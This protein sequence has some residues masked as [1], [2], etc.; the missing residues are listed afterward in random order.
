MLALSP[1][2]QSTE[3]VVK[4]DFEDNKTHA[5]SDTEEVLL[6]ITSSDM[7]SVVNS[8]GTLT[9]DAL[10]ARFKSYDTRATGRVNGIKLGEK[11]GIELKAATSYS[12][13]FE[14]R[15]DEIIRPDSSDNSGCS[16]SCRM[17]LMYIYKN[18]K[19]PT[20]VNFD[21]YKTDGSLEA[22]KGW[23][24]PWNLK[25][26]N[27]YSFT[28]EFTTDATVADNAYW[29]APMSYGGM[30]SSYRNLKLASADGVTELD[31]GNMANIS[32]SADLN[33]PTYNDQ[34]K[35]TAVSFPEIKLTQSGTVPL[36][37]NNGSITL[38]ALGARF[39]SYDTNATGRVNGIKIG[40]KQGLSLNPSTTYQIKF[41]YRLDEIIRPD[42][43][44]SKG[45]SYSC[46]SP[47]FY[48]YR[49]GQNPTTVTFDRYKADGSLEATKGWQNPWN[50]TVG[51]WYDFTLEFTTAS[52]IANNATYLAPISYGGMKSTYRNL[53]IFTNGEMVAAVDLGA[54]SD[55]PEFADISTPTYNDTNKNTVKSFPEIAISQAIGTPTG[56]TD[57]DHCL[58]ID[59]KKHKNSNTTPIVNIDTDYSV[60]KNTEYTV[61]FDYY[62]KSDSKEGNAFGLMA[63]GEADSNTK[64]FENSL[65]GEWRHFEAEYS[66]VQIGEIA[67]PNRFFSLI[68]ASTEIQIYID[69]FVITEHT[70]FDETAIPAVQIIDFEADDFTAVGEYERIT[71]DKLPDNSYS[72]GSQG[73]LLCDNA[74]NSGY[75]YY[76]FDNLTFKSNTTYEIS[77]DYYVPQPY[78]NEWTLGFG[79]NATYLGT[80]NGLQFVKFSH[81]ETTT[82][83]KT[84]KYTVTTGE[85]LHNYAAVSLA[86]YPGKTVY[87]DNVT[88]TQLCQITAESASL[89]QGE[90][91]G[92]G[93][94]KVGEKVTVKAIPLNGCDFDGWYE[95]GEKLANVGN[96]YTF[97]ASVDRNLEA[98]FTGR[99]IKPSYFVQDFEDLET[100][101]LMENIFEICED[102]NN[103]R[104]GKKSLH[105]LSTKMESGSSD[106]FVP[107]L[108]NLRNK[109]KGDTEYDIYMWVKLIT[110]NESPTFFSI[111]E[112]LENPSVPNTY[113]YNILKAVHT[114]T[115]T[116]GDGTTDGEWFRIHIG[117]LLL[118]DINS[119]TIMF[120]MGKFTPLTATNPSI[121]ELYVDDIEIVEN[122]VNFEKKK[123]CYS[124]VDM[125]ENGDFESGDEFWADLLPGMTVAPVGK[126][127]EEWQQ[128]NKLV[129]KDL[130]GAAYEKSISVKENALYTV[131]F[132]ARAEKSADFRLQ[133]TSNLG[134]DGL[135]SQFGDGS[136]AIVSLTDKWKRYSITVETIEG[137]NSL[138]LQLSNSGGT[139]EID[140]LN[141]YIAG[142]G[143]EA[144]PNTYVERLLRVSTVYGDG[145]T[146]G[147]YITEDALLPQTGQASTPYFIAASV[148]MA[149]VAMLGCL[150]FKR[151]NNLR[152]KEK[153]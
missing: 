152:L 69:N 148:F 9:L 88:A 134:K 74:G 42:S 128:R 51:K 126:G 95:N 139:V 83:W 122:V 141:M 45:C 47:L 25:V 48:I 113:T 90:T 31:F 106:R 61:E 140:N 54:M 78:Y 65:S 149:S 86:V 32:D 110:N 15:I 143:V 66:V 20:T 56:G 138:I 96:V 23:Q 50:M 125:F 27:W 94:Y 111:V 22:T 29:L 107:L 2:V 3:T 99:S 77:V 131:A 109:L 115:A 92:G 117:T 19:D 84:A 153:E 21:R 147:D 18:G 136:N 44:E 11:Q 28:L 124:I 112:Q 62:L 43:T 59:A 34:N 91:T 132:Y 102:S 30:K 135:I 79:Y 108:S 39:K 116:S 121:D 80:G 145:V 52:T 57:G 58:L 40:A 89:K 12:V 49:D 68:I 55:I 70:L 98:R 120:H 81:T 129:I 33:T 137:V 93:G 146:D 104:S 8:G 150:V 119:D 101:A 24:N 36:Q 118:T 114:P 97:T 16:Y 26:G 37:K 4:Y 67:N 85:V 64:W 75:Q 130:A 87:F 144:D 82:G 151:T 73:Y 123:Y 72:N 41:E 100:K 10:G 60:K 14:F 63:D 35:N 53:Q 13:S 46:R 71:S 127:A 6:S 142:R 103:S 105:V 38:D 76:N 17:P 1:N 133:L 5:V 7:N